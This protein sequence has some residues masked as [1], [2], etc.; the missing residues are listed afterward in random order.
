MFSQK[1]ARHRSFSYEPRYYNPE[2]DD[3]IKRRMRMQS[4]VH[5]GKSPGIL[6]LVILGIL[7]ALVYFQLA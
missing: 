7:S 3:R 5:R 2:R 4:K 1:R 6:R